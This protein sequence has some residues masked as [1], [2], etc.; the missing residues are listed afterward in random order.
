[1]TLLCVP[2]VACTV[3]AMRADA[4][5]AA[6]AGADLVEIRLDFI[7]KFRP[8]EDLPRL[9]RGCPLP[10]IATYRSEPRLSPTMLALATLPYVV[11]SQA[12]YRAPRAGL[13]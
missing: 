3:E 4:A 9:L 2:L 10:A 13:V 5:A 6:A 12:G 11:L 7:G 8:R 1:M